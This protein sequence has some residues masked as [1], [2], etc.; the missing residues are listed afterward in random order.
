M[1]LP[2]TPPADS[3]IDTTDW[4][5]FRATIDKIEK[6]QTPDLAWLEIAKSVA[7]RAFLYETENVLAEII[8]IAR[9]HEAG[10]PSGFTVDSKSNLDKLTINVPY[11]TDKPPSSSGLWILGLLGIGGLTVA[12]WPRKGRT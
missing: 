11:F 9:K 8:G 5:I 2:V 4:A 7:H 1:N 12:F 3:K 10:V 6:G